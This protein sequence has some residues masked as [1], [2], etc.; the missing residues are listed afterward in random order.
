MLLICQLPEGIRHLS[1][2]AFVTGTVFVPTTLCHAE[3]F[4]TVPVKVGEG[5]EV[6][7]KL[8]VNVSVMTRVSPAASVVVYL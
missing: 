3:K 6:G 8:T 7:G 2:A 4:S 1:R 5:V